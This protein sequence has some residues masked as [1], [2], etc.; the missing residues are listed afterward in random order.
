MTGPS[1]TGAYT[2][3]VDLP[4]GLHAYK[5]VYDDASGAAQWILNPTEARRKYIGR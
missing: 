5:I 2:A 3:T 4:P 1:V